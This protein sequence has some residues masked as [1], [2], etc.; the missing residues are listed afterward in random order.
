MSHSFSSAI[1]VY[2]DK[3]ISEV[4][5]AK[6]CGIRCSSWKVG[7][8]P[9]RHTHS[10]IFDLDLGSQINQDQERYYWQGSLSSYRIMTPFLFFVSCLVLL[11]GK[12][13]AYM[14]FSRLQTRAVHPVQKKILALRAGTNDDYDTLIENVKKTTPKGSVI[15]VKYGG[16]A[17]ENEELKRY[18]CEDIAA[19]CRV[20]FHKTMLVTVVVQ[21]LYHFALCLLDSTRITDW[22][23]ACHCSRWWT[24]DRQHVAEVGDRIQVLTR[25]ACDRQEDDGSSADGIVRL[26]Q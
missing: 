21:T 5:L 17:M 4:T 19:L 25:I 23:L 13:S 9:T 14:P 7:N 2:S 12:I 20:S 1:R 24:S 15:V 11:A 22:Y 16:H 6:M 8:D 3:K 18:F 10:Q 26:N